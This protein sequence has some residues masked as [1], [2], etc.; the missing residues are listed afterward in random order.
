MGKTIVE[1]IL[2]DH[3]DQ[4]DISKDDLIVFSVD[5]AMAQDGSAGLVIDQ[6]NALDTTVS[7]PKKIT[8]IIDHSSP[9]PLVGV[10]E[11]HRKIREFTAQNDIKLFDVGCG[12]CHQLMIESGKI[13]PS[14]LIVGGESHSCMYGALNTLALSVGSTDLAAVIAT[15]N[16]W[17]IIPGTVK[18]ELK[19]EFAPGVTVRDLIFHLISIFSLEYSTVRNFVIE[20]SGQALEHISMA[21]RFSICNMAGEMGALTS[22]MPYD[23]IT[24]DWM[25]EHDIEG[26]VAVDSD[27][28]ADYIETIVVQLEEVKNMIALPHDVTNVDYLSK[29]KDVYIDQAIIGTCS[30]GQVEDYEKAAN[31]LKG[32][33]VSVRL[34]IV[35]SSKNVY[36]ELIAKGI[37]DIFLDA[38]AVILPPGCGPCVGAHMG[39][40]SG[41]E[42]VL[43]TSNRNY[44]GTMGSVDSQVYLASPEV[45][46]A[47]AIVGII[48]GL[49]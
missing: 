6:F 5:Q 8:F 3:C 1:K 36:K 25:A 20:Y 37:I 38:G 29:V 33:K 40:V 19:G 17:G 48:C 30:A 2:L 27:E 9:S 4:E 42:V 14:S 7:D 35:I 18:V 41:G 31:I 11:I 12:I 44:K 21:G 45:V 22:I 34:L 43:S 32:Q 15:N 13:V 26:G 16:M 23:E 24:R 49:G 39:I 47:S 46:A 10:S 28:D